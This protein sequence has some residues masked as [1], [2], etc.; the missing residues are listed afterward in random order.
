MPD[1]ENICE[2]VAKARFRSKIDLLDAYEQVRIVPD[3][4]PKTV[5][6]M[7]WGTYTSAVMQQGDCNM[8]ATFQ[9][10]MTSIF[11][12]VIGVF[13]HVYI[14]DIFI[15]LDSIEEHEAHLCIIFDRLHEQTLYLKWAKCELYAKQIDC[16]GYIIDDEGLHA[17]SD[18]LT[19]ILEWHT[20]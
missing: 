1:Q 19:R 6:A 7:I 18:K 2:D 14:D 10:L 15:F 8:P 12:D 13:M 11:Q 4:I 17:D 16:L 9:H 5:F 3:D 20:P